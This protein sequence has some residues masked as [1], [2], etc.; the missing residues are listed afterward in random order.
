MREYSIPALVDVPATASLADVVF[1][2]AASQPHSVIMR[3]LD[4]G[5][6]GA[7]GAPGEPDGPS[8]WHDVT[9][10]QFRDEVTAL[11]KGLIAAGV[12]P[13]DRVALMSRTRYEWTL[14]DYA[15][16]AAGAVTV[17]I[18]ETSSAEQVEWILSDSGASAAFAETQAHADAIRQAGVAAVQNVWLIEG[19]DGTVAGPDGASVTDEQLEQRRTA[20]KAADL[21]TIIYTSGTTGRPKGC[22]I[23]H[24][25]L[26]SDVRN[27]VEGSLAG[28][29]RDRRQLDPAV[30][31]AGAFV[32]PDHPGRLPGIRRD[33]GALARHQDT[34]R[35]PARVPAH[36]PARRAA[37]VRE[38]L[39]H[40]GAAGFGEQG[41]EP[42]LRRRRWPPPSPGARPPAPTAPLRARRS[43][44]ATRCST[45]SSTPS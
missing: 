43:G 12:S 15:I 45:G 27:A 36:V 21:A 44:C 38:G 2:R 32:R 4:G 9:A 23:T 42:D 34:G 35:G 7:P 28:G 16:W 24:G 18:Y 8:G 29:V 11:A 31:A 39:Q 3:R 22:E 25:N 26:L 14:V 6:P 17:P 40:R 20:R 5:G 37:G 10:G 30:P 33:P 13:G 1:T 19:P 41:E